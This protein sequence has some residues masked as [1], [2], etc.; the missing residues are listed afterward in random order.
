M[1]QEALPA[2]SMPPPA[3]FPDAQQG[4]PALGMDISAAGGAPQQ[5]P[6]QGAAAAGPPQSPPAPSHQQT[7]AA[8]RHFTAI[9]GE[10]EKA[11]KDPDVGKADIKSKVIDGVT[12]LVARG[13]MPAADAVKTLSTFPARPFDQRKW[14][15]THLQQ[16]QQA[17][18]AV[19]E[20]H[21]AG[22]PGSGDFATE[23]AMHNSGSPDDH[24]GTMAG[25]MSAHYAGRA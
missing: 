17:E 6:G 24:L 23:S 5:A 16:T 22:N 25:M 4:Q 3:P 14:L 2:T 20:H 21:R 15:Q 12:R 13:I 7:V 9:G 18:M 10:L 1:A 11:L 8:L 19:L